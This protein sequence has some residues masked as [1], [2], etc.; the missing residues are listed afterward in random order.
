MN[1][2]NK[3]EKNQ[4]EA[5]RATT[6]VVSRVQINTIGTKNIPIIF[7]PG[8]MGTRLISQAGSNYA[9]AWD[10][11]DLM[12]MLNLAG[13]GADIKG[14]LLNPDLTK[15]NVRR[16]GDDLTDSQQDRGWGGIAWANYGKAIENL[17]ETSKKYGNCSNAYAYGY[18][19]RQ[20]NKISGQGLQKFIKKVLEKEQAEK[21]IIVTHSMGG[22]VTRWACKNG[23]A[24]S[25]LG[26]IHVTQP[27]TG[28][29]VLYRKFKT[30][31]KA[32]WIKDIDGGGYV[33]EALDSSKSQRR[34]KEKIAE[35]VFSSI[36]GS[37]PEDFQQIASGLYGV[38]ELLPTKYHPN[39]QPHKHWILLDEKLK[40]EFSVYLS[41][42]YSL[43]RDDTGKVGLFNYQYNQLSQ[44]SMRAV[45]TYNFQPQE[46]KLKKR[47]GIFIKHRINSAEK[48]HEDLGL[49]F[50]PNTF[51]IAVEAHETDT[52][53]QLEQIGGSVNT[54]RLAKKGDGTVTL[55]SQIALKV[56]EGNQHIFVDPS[57]KTHAE[58][59]DSAPINT[60]VNEFIAQIMLKE[61]RT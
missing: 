32:G 39:F 2:K 36:V 14:I 60:K 20:S 11:D 46:D 50:H 37:T 23:S 58:V 51:V 10:P 47:T 31:T 7:V 41:N 15:L 59:F 24:S 30:G 48:F 22:L 19:W 56:P 28:A 27:A 61:M 38:F 16:L 45:P 49:W 17:Q 21:V 42:P 57:I 52:G 5:V 9:W 33:L 54:T 26:V 12:S 43:Y 34:V 53:T 40:E 6:N 29:V 25:V 13:M 44:T 1:K 8:V 18:D 3:P 35:S 55:G 4:F